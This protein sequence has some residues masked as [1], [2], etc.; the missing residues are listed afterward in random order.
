[1]YSM[2]VCM[3]V[4]L[5]VSRQMIWIKPLMLLH[6]VFINFFEVWISDENQ[7]MAMLLPPPPPPSLNEYIDFSPFLY[8][9]VC[10]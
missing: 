7:M 4:C 10:M 1:M 3:Y 5:S 6:N 9:Y 8:I 2:Y